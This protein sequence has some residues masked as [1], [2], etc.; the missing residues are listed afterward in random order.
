MKI[1]A[2]PVTIALPLRDSGSRPPQGEAAGEVFSLAE[3]GA[4][5]SSAPGKSCPLTHGRLQPF[6]G[7]SL[8]GSVEPSPD[9]VAEAYRRADALRPNGLLADLGKYKDDQLLRNPGGDAYNLPKKTVE[10]LRQHASLAHRV[11]KDLS[12][13]WENGKRFLQNLAFGAETA[14]RDPSGQ[15]RTKRGRGLLGTLGSFFKNAASALTLGLYTPEG[16]SRPSGLVERVTHFL[17]KTKEA[18]L[19][20]LVQGVPSSVNGM[21]KNLILAG[22]NLVEVIPDATLGHLDAGRKATTAV[23]DNGQVLVEYLTDV[24]P[25]G[26]AWLRVHAGSL[27]GRKAPIVYNL[28]KPEHSTDDLRWETVRNT[29]FRKTIETLGALLADAVILGVIGQTLSSGRHSEDR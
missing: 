14:Y 24:I 21:G 19:T 25:G 13:A 11:G 29:P 5:P 20:D 3:D 9:Q 15:I 12:D 22:W 6:T 2:P 26:D 16:E 23:F 27:R 8:Q 1:Q 10:D 4:A 28:S 17:R 7:L 18:L